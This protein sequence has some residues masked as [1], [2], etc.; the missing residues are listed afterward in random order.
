LSFTSFAALRSSAIVVDPCRPTRACGSHRAR[1]CESP[2]RKSTLLALDQDAAGRGAAALGI[3]GRV[4]AADLRPC[5]HVVVYVVRS[6]AI[7]G[8]RRR[9]LPAD[10]RLWKTSCA[11][12]GKSAE[13]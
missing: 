1:D 8:N 7:V 3:A 10:A 4:D 2:P 5:V 13:N 6:G 12:W 11:R 9:P